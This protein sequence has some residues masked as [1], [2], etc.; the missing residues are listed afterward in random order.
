MPAL[1]EP[2]RRLALALA[3][4]LLAA[5]L[6]A[7]ALG[8][9]V[10]RDIERQHTM[11]TAALADTLARTGGALPQ[12]LAQLP[13][14]AVAGAWRRAEVRDG[15]GRLLAQAQGPHPVPLS[16]HWFEQALRLPAEPPPRGL[17]VDGQVLQVQAWVDPTHA[18][19]LLWQ[20]LQVLALAAPAAMLA[21]AALFAR[22]RQRLARAVDDTLAVTERLGD[23][24]YRPLTHAEVPELAPLARGLDR[25]HERLRALYALQATQLEA[26]RLQAHHD[27]LT[28]LA[29]RRHFIAGLEALLRSDD[30]PPQATLVLLRL[31]DL[32]GLNRRLGRRSAD[33]VLQAV[34]QVLQNYPQRVAHCLIGRLDGGDFALLLPTAGVGADTTQAL[35]AAVAAGLVAVDPQARVVVTSIELRPAQGGDQVLAVADLALREA[36]SEAGLAAPEPEVEPGGAASEVL[37]TDDETTGWHRRLMRALSQGRVRLGE[38]PVCTPDG[39]TLMIDSPLRVQLVAGGPFEPAARWLSQAVRSQLSVAID[40]RALML[41]L[42]AIARDG[43]ARCINFAAA[44]VVS[45]VFVDSV[46]R[47]LASAP[48]AACRLWVDL[49]ETLAVESPQRVRELSRRWRP[50]GVMLGLE[51]AGAA[52]SA[53][54]GLPDLGLDC[55]RIDARFVNGI[56]AAE[57]ADARRYL[58]GL[59]QLVQGVGL[60]VTAEGVRATEDLDVLWSLGFDAAT[61]PALQPATSPAPT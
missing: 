40:E 39:R 30:A 13:G 26:L 51:H 5:L 10:R 28:G 36:E 32:A 11:A 53:D 1:S 49:P 42:A 20:A 35:R 6:L 7:L 21:V 27:L 54:Q 57:A 16:P 60:S 37:A 31:L 34:A 18:L 47:R 3:A 41:A 17:Q 45:N 24:A 61:G 55:V 12:R 15:T 33:R 8:G 48:E 46:T 52:L 2:Q 59:V 4:P 50:L 44:S 38:F 58:Q 56:A 9:L 29:N 25:L 19:G 22:Q 43:Q 23:A 14:W